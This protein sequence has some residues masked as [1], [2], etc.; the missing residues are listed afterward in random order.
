MK[1]LQKGDGDVRAISLFERELWQLG[2]E[3]C[4]SRL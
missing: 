2:L 1:Q 3:N 4:I